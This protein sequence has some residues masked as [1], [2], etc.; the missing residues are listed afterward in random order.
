MIEAH[1]HAELSKQRQSA[2]LEKSIR[3]LF[4]L[5]TDSKACLPHI[6]ADVVA[7]FY[8]RVEGVLPIRSGPCS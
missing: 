2:F 3:P 6:Q 4:C 7:L 5:F 8:S 1:E